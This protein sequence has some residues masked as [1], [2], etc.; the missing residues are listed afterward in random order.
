MAIGRDDRLP[1]HVGGDVD[2][3]GNG[4]LADGGAAHVDDDVGSDLT[5]PS[6]RREVHEVDAEVNT[7]VGGAAIAEAEGDGVARAVAGIGAVDIGSLAAALIVFIEHEQIFVRPIGEAADGDGPLARPASAASVGLVRLRAVGKFGGVVEVVVVGIARRTVVDVAGAA[8][9]EAVSAVVERIEAVVDLPAVGQSVTVRVGAQRIGLANDDFRP[10]VGLRGAVAAGRVGGE[11]RGVIDRAGGGA[12]E[13]ELGVGRREQFGERSVLS[14]EE[15]FGATVEILILAVAVVQP[16]TLGVGFG[17]SGLLPS[18]KRLDCVVGPVAEI[19]AVRAVGVLVDRGGKLQRFAVSVGPTVA[20]GILDAIGETV[21]VGVA[22]ERISHRAGRLAGAVVA[23][24]L[25]ADAGHRRMVLHHGMKRG[26]QV[27]DE[28]GGPIAVAVGRQIGRR[29]G[30]R[31]PADLESVRQA[32]AVAVGAGR[33]RAAGG[34]VGVDVAVAP[35]L[36][37][38]GRKRLAVALVDVDQSVVVVIAVVEAGR[39]DDLAQDDGSIARRSGDNAVKRCFGFDDVAAGCGDVP[40]VAPKPD[41][42][43]CFGYGVSAD[44]DAGQRRC[45]GHPG[46]GLHL[47]HVG[48]GIGTRTVGKNEFRRTA[49]GADHGRAGDTEEGFVARVDG[50]AP[51]GRE[52]AAGVARIAIDDAELLLGHGGV[53]KIRQRDRELVKGAAG[54]EA[55]VVDGPTVAVLRIAL[56]QEREPRHHLLGRDGDIAPC[57]GEPNAHDVVVVDLVAVIG[58]EGDKEALRVAQGLDAAGDLAHV[59]RGRPEAEIAGRGGLEEA[60]FDR[61][62]TGNRDVVVGEPPLFLV[63][64]VDRQAGCHL[65]GP[66]PS[67]IQGRVIASVAVE[68]GES[69]TLVPNAVVVGVDK[70]LEAGSVSV[71]PA[72]DR[73]VVVGLGIGDGIPD[74]LDGH[75]GADHH[76]VAG[77]TNRFAVGG[78]ESQFAI[79]RLCVI[80]KRLDKGVVERGFV[81]A[82]IERR[83]ASRG[84]SVALEEGA[85]PQDVEAL[86]QAGLHGEG[87]LVVRFVHLRRARIVVV[88]KKLDGCRIEIGHTEGGHH[89][90]LVGDRTRVARPPRGST[91]S[92]VFAETDFISQL[93]AGRRLGN[94]G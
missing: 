80:V 1:A 16:V 77:S 70:G 53:I 57:L 34:E 58:R 10:T 3:V 79:G 7:S 24:A 37:V 21:T 25:R 17:G 50:D 84:I 89:H 47:D 43:V 20:V 15:D 26:I 66:G 83:F 38:S 41:V 31:A 73:I 13:A 18:L 71:L 92:L 78:G 64:T 35:R 44:G 19:R 5:L 54:T 67:G 28:V 49:V 2:L 62:C 75:V 11:Q 52:G 91:S 8:V 72:R 65:G 93:R 39:L 4:A 88:R 42:A 14:L 56:G 45:V 6:I 33:K 87:P 48:H 69:F 9:A 32:V 30:R 55:A 85:G 59:G 68:I 60:D 86:A 82:G 12:A 40:R 23:L 36:G 27:A 94:T 63:G 46:V 51:D 90:F 29:R 74:F 76:F 22:I 61:R 81:M